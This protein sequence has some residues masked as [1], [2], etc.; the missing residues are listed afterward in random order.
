MELTLGTAINMGTGIPNDVVGSV[1]AEEGLGDDVLVTVESGVYSGIP[2][3]GIDFGVAHNAQALIPHEVQFDFY[4]GMGIPFTFMGAGEMD[5]MGHV[6]ATKFGD[7]SPGCGGFVDITQ[8]S[9]HVLFCSTFTARG[10]EVEFGGGRLRIVREGTQKKLVKRVT[11]ISYNGEIARRN[12]QKMHFVTERAVFELRPEGPVL[13][14]I[15]PGVELQ[16]DILGQMEFK[17]II[18][19]DLKITDESLYAERPFGLKAKLQ[20]K[21]KEKGSYATQR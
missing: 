16:R 9:G 7:R 1:I 6:N 5:E 10:L 20:A 15:A 17:P 18:A 2:E 13:I 21:A 14:E 11:Q 19:P 3:G 8:N 4:N 12:G